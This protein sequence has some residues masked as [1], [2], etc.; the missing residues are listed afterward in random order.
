MRPLF[1]AA[2]LSFSQV[3]L[4]RTDPDSGPPDVLYPTLP[5]QAASIDRFVPEGWRTEADLRGHLDAGNTP[6]ALLLLRM[7]DPAN[8]LAPGTFRSER[9]DTNPRMLVALI[10]DAGGGWRRVMANHVLIPRGDSPNM[11][12]YL[13]ESPAD[14]LR[15]HANRTWSVN[16][17]SWSSA[18][19]WDTS[20]TTFTFRLE[21]DCMRLVGLDEDALHR[22]SGET[23]ALSVNFLT[24]RASKRD[25]SIEESMPR[26]E[27]WTRLA[28]NARV[29][30]DDIGDGFG[31]APALVPF[32]ESMR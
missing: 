6:D 11:D 4:A 12:D 9:V 3:A 23:T 31:Y 22:G 7:D 10:A 32:A 14:A 17:H 20:E 25:G 19:S 21:G 13:G 15:I 29:C 1:L 5:A 16:L 24:G 2:A 18:G 8:V 27:R 28:S 30:I 26:P